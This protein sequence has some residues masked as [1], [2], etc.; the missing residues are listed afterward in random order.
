[1]A[2][3]RPRQIVGGF[4][5]ARSDRKPS[6]ARWTASGER[7]GYPAYGASA[8]R[9]TGCRSASASTLRVRRD[10][11]G[12]PRDLCISARRRSPVSSSRPARTAAHEPGDMR[13]QT[14]PPRGAGPGGARARSARASTGQAPPGVRWPGVPPAARRGGGG[15]VSFQV[16]ASVA[17]VRRVPAAGVRRRCG[18]ACRRARPPGRRGRQRARRAAQ[19]A[20]PPRRPSP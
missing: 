19:G 17:R 16:A 14:K 11:R 15:G 6:T 1:M 5:E 2:T 12:G 9:P 7:L 18:S 10:L 8:I 3:R 20:T 4:R 13:R